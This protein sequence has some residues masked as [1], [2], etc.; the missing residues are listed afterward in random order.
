MLTASQFTYASPDDA[1]WRRATIHCIELATGKRRLRRLYEDYCRGPAVEDF[2]AEAV[3]RLGLH[4]KASGSGLDAIPQQGPLVVVAN[5]PYGVVDGLVLGYLISRVRPDFRII[6]NSV[7]YRLPEIRHHFLPI[8]FSET[9]EALR[10]N[11]ESRR[12]A[13]D[14]LS[15]G[16]CIAIF[17]GGTVSTAQS[18]LGPATDPEW[19]PFLARLIRESRATVVP[20][21]FEG[22]NSRLFQWASLVSMTLRLSLLFREVVNKMDSE[23]RAHIGAPI[24]YDRLP[25]LSDRRELVEHLRQATYALRRPKLEKRRA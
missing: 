3:T 10:T 5:H 8:D 17:P 4:V 23:T 15:Q 2:F 18:P 16:R 25:P 6:V 1:F 19:K 24:A 20:I 14:D 11:L 9:R 22:Q 13:L 21:Y 7:L 12:A